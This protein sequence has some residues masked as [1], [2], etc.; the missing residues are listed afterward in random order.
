MAYYSDKFKYFPN[1]ENK[2]KFSQ[3][4]EN[5]GTALTQTSIFISGSRIPQMNILLN[6]QI[7]LIA[8]SMKL[9]CLQVW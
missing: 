8:K 5:T 6:Q 9:Y 2:N 7:I 4:T 1:S 3:V